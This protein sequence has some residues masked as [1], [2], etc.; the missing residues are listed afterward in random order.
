MTEQAPDAYSM[1][2]DLPAGPRPPNHYELLELELFCSYHERINHAVRKQFRL[3]KPCQNHPER[4]TR[5]AVQDILNAIATA[6]VVLTD[7]RRKEEYDRTLA[8]E[9]NIDRDKHLAEQVAAPLPEF[10]IAV[11]AGPSLVDERVQLV[12]GTAITIGSDLHCA[13][14][15]KAGRVGEK[16]CRIEFVEAEWWVRSLD[17]Q[18]TFQVNDEMCAES[19]LND[20]DYFDVGGYRLKVA[21]IDRQAGDKRRAV[22]LAPPLSMIILRGVS[23][24]SPTFNMLPPQRALIGHGDTALWQLPH[25][26]VSRHHCAVQ[27]VGDRWEIEDLESTNGTFVNGTEIMRHLLHD[28]DVLTVGQFDILVSLRV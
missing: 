6:R 14:P 27:S 12:E 13:L 20:A 3:I 15:L 9:L 28:R 8:A 25:S 2:L 1:Y 7:P 5:E 10:E 17:P 4:A 21:S 26:T 23:I 11:I 19:V 22:G 16:H 24:P 18:Y